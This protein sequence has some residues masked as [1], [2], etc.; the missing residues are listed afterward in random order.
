MNDTEINTGIFLW[1]SPRKFSTQA[2]RDS[3]DMW[4]SRQLGWW[5]KQQALAV[6]CLSDRAQSP[7]S[8]SS[9][10]LSCCGFHCHRHDCPARVPSVATLSVAAIRYS[11]RT[12]RHVHRVH[13]RDFESCSVQ[14]PRSMSKT[15]EQ[16]GK[17]P[18]DGGLEACSFLFFSQ[19]MPRFCGFCLNLRIGLNSLGVRMTVADKDIERIS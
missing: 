12:D 2:K 11:G 6:P 5:H 10:S 19:L 18:S 8:S 17:L 3:K 1:W 15:L 16:K 9:A 13:F 4:R 14:P 7:D